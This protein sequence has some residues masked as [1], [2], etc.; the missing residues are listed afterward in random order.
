MWVAYPN[1]EK[2]GQQQ[3]YLTP[4]LIVG[5][6]QMTQ[7]TYFVLGAG[8]QF[9]LTKSRTFNHQWLVIMRIPYF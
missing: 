1:G 2:D 6:F 7:H 8:F 3:L 9:A 5:R 4:Q